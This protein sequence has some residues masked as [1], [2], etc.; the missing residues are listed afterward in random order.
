M[1]NSF[2]DR[3]TTAA[4][5]VPQGDAFFPLPAPEKSTVFA[6]LLVPGFTLLAF[7]AAVEALRIANQ[8]SQQPLYQWRVL[9]VDGEPVYS[10]SGIPIGV[11]GAIDKLPRDTGLFVC[12]GNPAAEAMTPAVVGAVQRHHRFGGTVGGIC[13]G[14]VALARAGLLGD[15][16][17]TLHWENLPAFRTHFPDL[18]PKETKYE[19]DGRLMTCGGGSAAIDMMLDLIGRD[20]G[21]AFAAMVSEMCLRK[22]AVG[23]EEEQR[24]STSV[25]IRT[26]HPGLLSMVELMK[27]HLEDPLTMEEL[28]LTSGYSRRHIERLF[29]SVFGKTPGEFYRGLRLDHGRMLLSSTDLELIDVAT[30][31]GYGSVG[32]FSRCFKARFGVAPTAYNRAL[33]RARRTTRRE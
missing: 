33:G 29:M 28:A 18:L 21:E 8:L 31:C 25:L 9:S 22:V 26:R 2:K 11:E 13:T 23:R 4:P 27:S 30:A 16:A 1:E 10:S 17:F 14:A 7:S 24:S 20:H 32:H 6:F 12:S 5:V 15:K 19:I 3:F